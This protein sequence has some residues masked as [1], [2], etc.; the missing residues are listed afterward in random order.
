MPSP[1]FSTSAAIPPGSRRPAAFTLVELL[2]VI[3][4]IGTLVGLL[5]PA[6]QAAREAARR[7]QCGNNL[8]QLGLGFQNYLSAKQGFPASLYD[9]NETLQDGNDP[10]LPSNSHKALLLPFIEEANLASRYSLKKHW[11][12]ATSNSGQAADPA[13]GI[14]A[15]SNL[16]LAMTN[17]PSFLCPSTPGRDKILSIPI[18]TNSGSSYSATAKSGR[19]AFTVAQPLGQTDYDC[20]NG[21]KSNVIGTSTADD[22]YYDLPN[23]AKNPEWSRAALQKNK[24]T[25]LREILDGTSKTIML[26]E[27]AGRPDVWRGKKKLTV[28]DTSGTTPQTAPSDS[29]VGWAD[30]DAPFSIDACTTAGLVYKTLNY[31]ASKDCG[32]GVADKA[33]NGTNANE[34]FAFHPGGM[35]VVMVD[36]SAQ[37][38]ADDMDLRTFAALLTKRGGES[39]Q[40]P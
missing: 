12:D 13:L 8:R 15:D 38:F 29:G 36:G 24:R 25:P 34:A 30:S 5:L 7:S 16:A 17:V 4:I 2:V 37:F 32:S 33:F 10:A 19:P 3:A 6:V 18:R 14:P 23:N 22:P 40:A 26:V 35:M 20:M 28:S 1:A 21:I 9:Q 27:C 39:A 31:C 11:W